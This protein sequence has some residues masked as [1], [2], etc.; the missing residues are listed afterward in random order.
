MTDE[1]KLLVRAELDRRTEPPTTRAEL[2]RE[3]GVTRGLLTKILR[4]S[5]EPGLRQHASAL[6]PRICEILAV[7][8]P[9]ELG[10]LADRRRRSEEEERRQRIDQL[11]QRMDMDQ[12]VAT[13]T[14]LSTMLRRT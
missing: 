9:H 6:V 10:A 1:W 14:F 4:T 12:L 5:N 2:A 11:V 8:M 13:E 7:P 3:L